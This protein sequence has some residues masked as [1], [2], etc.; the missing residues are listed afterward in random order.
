VLP[1]AVLQDALGAVAAG[2]LPLLVHVDR[3]DDIVALLRAVRTVNDAG[4]VVALIIGGGAEAHVVASDI[5]SLGAS[6]LY[7]VHAESWSVWDTIR[8]RPDAPEIL[9]TAGA[10]G[11]IP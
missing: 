4:G 2:V 5:A 8:A 9:H 10:V 7:D 11:R 1:A 6:V 3:A